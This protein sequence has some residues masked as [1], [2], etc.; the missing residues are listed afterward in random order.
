VP[1]FF[2]IVGYTQMQYIYIIHSAW[3]VGLVEELVDWK[4]D[5]KK[6]G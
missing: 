2:K 5:V 6:K 4:E 3:I 1:V